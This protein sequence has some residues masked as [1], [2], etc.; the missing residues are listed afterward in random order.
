MTTRTKQKRTSQRR[1]F[2]DNTALSRLGSSSKLKDALVKEHAEDIVVVPA[3]VY[4]EWLVGQENDWEVSQ[5]RKLIDELPLANEQLAIAAG[6]A[7]RGLYGERC[8][9]CEMRKRPGIVDAVLAALAD[10]ADDVIYTCDTSDLTKLRDKLKH[11]ADV[12]FAHG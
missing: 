12:R 4:G 5:V 8:E 9:A 10:R 7:I 3:L 2:L 6:R 11:T 1:V